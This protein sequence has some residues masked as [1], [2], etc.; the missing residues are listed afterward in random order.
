MLRAQI[1]KG[2]L[3]GD[4][5][6][7]MTSV[8]MRNP[9]AE[10]EPLRISG[11]FNVTE[12]PISRQCY[13]NL[14]A[15]SYTGLDARNW[16]TGRLDNIYNK[17][18]LLINEYHHPADFRHGYIRNDVT[19]DRVLLSEEF[20]CFGKGTPTCP[21]IVVPEHI[22]EIPRGFRQAQ[23]LKK[24]ATSTPI[25]GVMRSHFEFSCLR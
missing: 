8:A 10:R 9:R 7:A 4:I 17:D 15:G 20:S 3:K 12:E 14:Y 16:N 25:I 21:G 6:V 19:C 2:A 23:K 18:C 24:R 13:Y 11:I 1:R 22:T 5:V